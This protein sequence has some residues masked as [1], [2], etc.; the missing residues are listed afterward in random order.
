MLEAAKCFPGGNSR[1]RCSD[2]TGPIH[3]YVILYQ[4]EGADPEVFGPYSTPNVAAGSLRRIATAAGTQLDVTYSALLATLELNIGGE[5]H[6]YQLVKVASSIQLDVHADIIGEEA[7]SNRI[8]T[9][10]RETDPAP[11]RLSGY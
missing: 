4:A 11:T 3:V 8:E 6:R 1:E 5:R 9:V 7:A 10:Y 2:T